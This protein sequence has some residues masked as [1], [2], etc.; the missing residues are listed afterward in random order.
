MQSKQQ[1]SERS[2]LN[3]PKMKT[4]SVFFTFA[5]VCF[6]T[7]GSDL[8]RGKGAVTQVN[9]GLGMGGEYFSRVAESAK[10]LLSC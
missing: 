2:V 10:F 5:A 3:E 6:K 7:N 4:E 8:G 9:K 1:N